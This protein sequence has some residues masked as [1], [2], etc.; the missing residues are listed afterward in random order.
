MS[1]SPCPGPRV[2]SHH[3]GKQNRSSGRS[4]EVGAGEREDSDPSSPARSAPE[5]TRGPIVRVFA[6]RPQP[7]SRSAL[8]VGRTLPAD[9]QRE[10]F[11]RSPTLPRRRPRASVA[12]CVRCRRLAAR[13]DVPLLKLSTSSTNE[14]VYRS[15]TQYQPAH[16]LFR[17]IRVS[18]MTPQAHSR[19]PETRASGS[20]MRV[21]SSEV[22]KD[23]RSFGFRGAPRRRPSA[24]VGPHRGRGG[25]A[26]PRRSQDARRRAPKMLL[27]LAPPFVPRQRLGLNGPEVGSGVSS[28]R[29][30][31]P[32]LRVR[33]DGPDGSV[34]ER[35]VLPADRVAQAPQRAFQRGGRHAVLLDSCALAAPTTVDKGSRVFR[36][37]VAVSPRFGGSAREPAWRRSSSRFD[38]RHELILSDRSLGRVAAD[39]TTARSAS[40]TPH[41]KW[42]VFDTVGGDT[43]R[44]WCG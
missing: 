5:P 44:S 10:D 35:V 2:A 20:R 25:G 11:H 41:A 18:F 29:V 32:G 1:S 34:R 30:G 36:S 23:Q 16:G 43:K 21:T 24:L 6:A 39:R 17:L 14:E 19:P 37:V 42:T 40:K 33:R 4:H 13:R 15:V 27:L 12:D 9:A 26:E 3:V 38:G 22:R 31:D 8:G 7:A 28:L